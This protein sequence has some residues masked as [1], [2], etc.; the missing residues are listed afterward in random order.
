MSLQTTEDVSALNCHEQIC[1]L[2]RSHFRVWEK[3]GD[4]NS[5]L[6]GFWSSPA[7][8]EKCPKEHG[9]REGERKTKVVHQG[10]TDGPVDQLRFAPF[11]LHHFSYSNTKESPEGPEPGTGHIRHHR[12]LGSPF[13]HTSPGAALCPGGTN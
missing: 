13:S 1:H 2:E 12:H 7:R 11:P 5:S 8:E 4:R 6:G 3:N 10:R 9:R